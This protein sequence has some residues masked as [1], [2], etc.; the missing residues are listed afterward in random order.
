MI[1]ARWRKPDDTTTFSQPLKELLRCAFMDHRAFIPGATTGT[2]ERYTLD[3]IADDVEHVRRALGWERL[4][5]YGHSLHG[6]IALEYARQHPRRISHV[7]M[8]GTPPCW[9]AAFGQAAEAYWASAASPER[10]ALL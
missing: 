3:M 5:V 6:L 9:G 1:V 10:K 2:Q 4:T 7:L 8:E